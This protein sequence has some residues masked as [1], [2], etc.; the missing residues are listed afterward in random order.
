[1]S[2]GDREPNLIPST[3]DRLLDDEPEVSREPLSNRFQNLHQLKK[4]VARDS[5]GPAEYT[6]GDAE[7]ATI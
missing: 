2:R 6:T 5:R 7:G 1:M 4:A 3:L